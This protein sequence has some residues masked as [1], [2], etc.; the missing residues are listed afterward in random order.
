MNRSRSHTLYK[1]LMECQSI[2]QSQ[3]PTAL[4]LPE[5]D[6]P[7][8]ED[9]HDMKHAEPYDEV[10]YSPNWR[11]RL[12]ALREIGEEIPTT[13]IQFLPGRMICRRRR[14]RIKRSY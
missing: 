10:G 14:R 13:M 4:A 8:E 9:T 6:T 7:D 3:S 12:S 11:E 5:E 1:Q 2:R